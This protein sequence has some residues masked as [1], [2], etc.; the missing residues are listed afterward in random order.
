[1]IVDYCIVEASETDELERLVK[2]RMQDEWQPIGGV[3]M[4]RYTYQTYTDGGQSAWWYTHAMVK[5]AHE[6]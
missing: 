6:P 5:Y 1:M 3:A 2:E 4:A